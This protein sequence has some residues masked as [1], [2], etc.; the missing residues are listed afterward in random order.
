MPIYEFNFFKE[1]TGLVLAEEKSYVTRFVE[2]VLWRDLKHITNLQEHA[3][4]EGVPE[5][6]AISFKS[7]NFLVRAVFDPQVNTIEIDRD[8]FVTV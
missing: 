7:K 2:H 6:Y 4:R 5:A 3:T 1:N 8:F